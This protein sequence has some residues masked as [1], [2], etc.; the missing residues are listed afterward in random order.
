M[1]IVNGGVHKDIEDALRERNRRWRAS[2]RLM[3]KSVMI[4]HQIMGEGRTNTGYARVNE[5]ED[6]RGVQGFCVTTRNLMNGAN[7]TRRFSYENR[8]SPISREH[9]LTLAVRYRNIH[10]QVF[11]RI[12]D[13]YNA[14]VRDE[15]LRLAE[16]EVEEGQPLIQRL[17]GFSLPRWNEARFDFDEVLLGIVNRGRPMDEVEAAVHELCAEDAQASAL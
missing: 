10:A 11:N 9:A 6:H 17:Y 15:C 12:V 4:H 13:R 5:Y 1:G 16:R 2:S 8:R 3:I 14:L 7:T